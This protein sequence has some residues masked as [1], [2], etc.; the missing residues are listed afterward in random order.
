MAAENHEIPSDWLSFY[1]YRFQLIVTSHSPIVLSDILKEHVIL[2]S[3]DATVRSMESPTLG[4]NIAMQFLDVFYMDKG[5]IGE[6]AKEKIGNLISRIDRFQTNDSEERRELLYLAGSVGDPVGQKR[7]AEQDYEENPLC[8][9]P[10][11]RKWE[12]SSDE[13]RRKVLEYMRNNITRKLRG[14]DDLH[15]GKKKINGKN[16][17]IIMQNT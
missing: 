13:E 15:R 14:T 5:N 8:M 9:S 10:L 1:E 6:F 4:A 3:G 12:R 7:A 16:W 2:L 11:W 17:N